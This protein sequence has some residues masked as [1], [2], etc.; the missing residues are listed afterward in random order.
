MPRSTLKARV[1]QHRYQRELRRNYSDPALPLYGLPP[2]WQGIRGTAGVGVTWS[3]LFRSRVDRLGLVH[4][5]KDGASLTV[6]SYRA[7][8]AARYIDAAAGNDLARR[9]TPATIPLSAPSPLPES[10]WQ[11]A[12]IVVDGNPVTFRMLTADSEWVAV[13]Q[14][15]DVYIKVDGSR[16]D[17]AEVTLT[18]ITDTQPY[19]GNRAP[20]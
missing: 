6:S 15:D 20:S 12:T 5:T 18:R 19:L 9:V 3:S 8:A 17:P 7:E 16:F 10:D 14:L 4:R 2:G 11:A 1:E 13:A